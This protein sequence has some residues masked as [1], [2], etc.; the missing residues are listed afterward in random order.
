MKNEYVYWTDISYLADGNER[1]VLVHKLLTKNSIMDLLSEYNP[2]LVGTIP[3]DI[4]IESSDLDIICEVYDFDKFKQLLDTSFRHK[5]DYTCSI[6]IVDDITRITAKFICDG[7]LVEV[8][9][10][11]IPVLKQNGYRHMLIESKILGILGLE[12]RKRIVEY[13]KQGLKTEPAFA[14]LLKLGGNPYQAMLE[15]EELDQED[16]TNFLEEV[17][18]NG[19]A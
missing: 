12:A 2:V 15:L 18:A 19:E 14:K 3:I 10:Q 6:R 8:F 9:G 11:S 16:L 5:N 4:D 7:W 13:K 17:L 1:Q